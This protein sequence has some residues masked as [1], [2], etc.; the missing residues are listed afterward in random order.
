MLVKCNLVENVIKFLKIE[1]YPNSQSRL[2][3][4]GL[5]PGWI[6]YPQVPRT[7]TSTKFRHNGLFLVYRKKKTLETQVY[8]FVRKNEIKKLKTLFF[9]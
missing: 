1:K 3:L 6:Y 5:E 7:C 4:P 8:F 2:P 9:I